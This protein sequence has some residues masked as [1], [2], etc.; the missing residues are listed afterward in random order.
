MGGVLDKVKDS[1]EPLN[2]D[3]FV[4]WRSLKKIFDDPENLQNYFTPF[5]VDQPDGVVY[6]QDSPII[7]N[8][9]IPTNNDHHQ[10]HNSN[11]SNNNN[12]NSTTNSSGGGGNKKNSS[13][14]SY[15]LLSQNHKSSPS[16]TS[17]ITFAFTENQQV[18]AINQNLMQTINCKLQLIPP[19]LNH[20]TLN[21]DNYYL[22]ERLFLSI[23]ATII[24]NNDNYHNRHLATTLRD[25]P[26]TT[27][28]KKKIQNELQEYI[29]QY[30]FTLTKLSL[31]KT[32][33]S[34]RSLEGLS[35]ALRVNQTVVE[36]DLGGN[37]L[38]G[39]GL[40]LLMSGLRENKTI[41]RLN[42]SD[43]R[44]YDEGAFM[45][46]AFLMGSKSLKIVDLST[47]YISE[48]GFEALKQAALRNTTITS[49]FLE[50]NNIDP[51]KIYSIENILKRN[52]AVQYIL[53]TIMDGLPWNRKFKN[54][55]QSFKRGVMQTRTNSTLNISVE[56]ERTPLFRLMNKSGQQQGQG[57]GQQ[58]QQQQNL[59][60]PEQLPSSRF[61]VGKSEMIGKRPTMEDR[62]VA[63]GCYRGCQTSELYCVFD[64]HGG[65]AASDFAADHIYRI[66][67]E[68]LD[69]KPTPEEAFRSTFQSIHTQIS[70]WPFIGTTAASVYIKDSKV[71]VAN[72]GDSRVVLGKF[73]GVDPV[74]NG[75][76]GNS[77]NGSF[78]QQL[79]K[80]ERLTFDH[81]PVEESER[82]RILNSGGTVL[83]GRVNGMLAVSRA[84]G[85][86]FLTP[87]VTPEPHLKSFTISNEDKFLILA[88]DGVWD[89]I[90]DE[91]AVK[92]VANI[93]DPIESSETLR[94]LAFAQGSTDNISLLD[95]NTTKEMVDNLKKQMNDII[96][97][98]TSKEK[99]NSEAVSS[100]VGAGSDYEDNNDIYNDDD[101]I[102]KI[103]CFFMFDIQYEVSSNQL[104]SRSENNKHQ[105]KQNE[106]KQLSITG[107]LDSRECDVFLYIDAQSVKMQEH[108]SKWLKYVIMVS[109]AS[110]IQ[111][112][113]L[114]KQMD[115]SG[116]QSGASKISIVTIGMQ[117][118][119]D[120]YL[121]LLHLSTGVVIESM[122]NAFASAAFFQFVT[123]SLFEMRYLL[124]ILKARRPQAF[125]DGWVSLRREF[126]LFYL[127]FY[128]CLLGGFILLY[129]ASYYINLMILGLFSFWIPQIYNNAKKSIR[130]PFL[131]KYV[132]GISITRLLIPLYFYGCPKN[133]VLFE[134]NYYFAFALVLWMSLQ[135]FVLWLQN[136][137]GPQFFI[138]KRLLPPKYNY[139]RLITNKESEEQGCVICMND[140]EAN[141]STYGEIMTTP[142]NHLFHSKC[143]LQWMEFK[144]ECPTCRQA[145]PAT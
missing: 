73:K 67:G 127:K 44:A 33:L 24:A 37:E 91:D 79:W 58:Q 75:N 48:K 124:I 130:R 133:F 144:M 139:Y 87:Y 85:D 131:W 122:F 27:M 114:I 74:D 16:T 49:L 102:D 119:I 120:A 69:S 62:M 135:V 47:N 66:F 18:E 19:E 21:L 70:P 11:N 140:V 59:Q 93:P 12:N 20:F 50:D 116:T 39:T 121:C 115:F 88:C 143:L 56:E 55:I 10:I 112:F 4:F 14:E 137:L 97:D 110:F 84:L 41:T 65:K 108:K 134:P 60:P 145:L 26:L 76:G 68:F 99:K 77:S 82:Q 78:N 46:A 5:M 38:T 17:K 36:L 113:V 61:S 81:R 128:T 100:D 117:T 95:L 89:L 90:S 129:Y 107:F 72:V 45:I 13:K 103:P 80:T 105:Q 106:D 34:N 7:G 35:Q 3:A 141:S 30:Y 111:I 15:V 57:Q 136:R 40:A 63:Y 2:Q 8:D 92:I 29:A 1:G 43:V 23:C 118:M 125:A 98:A 9:I 132:I 25:T 71:Y 42:L 123:F 142:C 22:T 83:N 51:S 54:R 32:L 86:S 96:A 126:S 138:P 28:K 104:I 52:A 53:D 109:L 101:G 94:D 64:G 31:K 6:D